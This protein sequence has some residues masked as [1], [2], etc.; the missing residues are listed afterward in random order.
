MPAAYDTYDYPSYW[1]G[2]EYEHLSEVLAIKSFLDKI[3]KIGRVLEIGAGYG[4]LAPTYFFRSKKI[5][6]SDP[7]A[8]LLKIARQNLKNHKGVKFIQSK[9]ENLPRKIKPESVDL[10]LLVRVMHHLENPQQAFDVVNKLLKKR[11]YFVLEFANKY[12]FKAR[13][14]EFIR[15]NFTYPLDIFPKD[16]RSKKSIKEGVLPFYNY[17]PDIIKEMLKNSGF[18]IISQRSVSNIRS[19]FIKSVLPSSIL[20]SIEKC[21]QEPLSLINFGPS[22]FILAQKKG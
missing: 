1:K 16:K 14:I 21:L 19:T 17:H 18:K 10:V 20:L 8:K 13:C 4:R 7:S 15:G 11:A 3:P 12:H 22:I 6:L 5:I 2:R 9:L